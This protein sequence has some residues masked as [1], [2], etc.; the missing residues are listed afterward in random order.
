M[1]FFDQ[2]QQQTSAERDYL[3]AAPIIHS[4]L[5]GT[6][7]RAQYIAFLTRPTTTSNT[8]CRC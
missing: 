3:L 1:E 4:A 2:L 6:A 7:T 8:R 5:A